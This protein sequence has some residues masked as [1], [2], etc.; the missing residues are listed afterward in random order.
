[1]SRLRGFNR[2]SVNELVEEGVHMIY[3]S[4]LDEQKP[5]CI[6]VPEFD[7]IRVSPTIKLKGREFEDQA[8]VHEWLHAYEDLI[9]D[10]FKRHKEPKIDKWARR[11]IKRDRDLPDYIRSFFKDYGF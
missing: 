6:W 8:I 11:H 1:M 2:D 9:L 7:L 5:W 10:V 3:D 4:S